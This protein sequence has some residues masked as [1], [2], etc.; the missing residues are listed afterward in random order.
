[1]AKTKEKF[2]LIN[3]ILPAIAKKSADI[4]GRPVPDLAGSITKI[5]SAVISETETVW[6]KETK[7][8]D[9]SITLFNYTSRVRAYT[10][11]A[12][13]PEKSGAVMVD[14][15]TGGRKEATGVWA[16]KLES[17]QPGEKTVISYSL[18]G[19]ERGDWT[20]TDIFFRG[21][22]DVIGASK[23]DEKFLEEIRRQ[24][25]ALREMNA[26][27]QSS[28]ESDEPAEPIGEPSV[29]PPSGQT[30]LFGGEN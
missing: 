9:V 29:A 11:L 1:M 17:L 6:N 22:Q 16:W 28:G 18:S 7:Q 21:S 14:N 30:T 19:L 10:I 8:T 3:D 4:L 24:E 15:D 23:M 20:E 26:P 13:W 27:E 25:R 12:T 5:M 2:E